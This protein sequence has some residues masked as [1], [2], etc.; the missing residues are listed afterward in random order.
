MQTLDTVLRG[1]AIG[2]LLLSASVFWVNGPLSRKS[3]SVIALCLSVIP[4][5]L[6]SSPSLSL[7]EGVLQTG[8]LLAAALI[9]VLLYWAT[10]ELFLDEVH[11][12][13]WQLI[14]AVAIVGTAWLSQFGPSLGVLRGVCVLGFFVHA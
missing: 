14:C 2:A 8:L 5:L 6:L 1:C 4:Y 7:G 10:I 3:G 12:R 13:P 11:I 9:P